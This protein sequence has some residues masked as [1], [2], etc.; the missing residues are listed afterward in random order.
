[1][2]LSAVTGKLNFESAYGTENLFKYL[3]KILQK[4]F[5]PFFFSLNF[6]L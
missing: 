4:S 5:Y 1:M 3:L 2:L 6:E